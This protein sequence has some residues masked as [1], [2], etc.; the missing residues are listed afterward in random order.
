M[1]KAVFKKNRQDDDIRP[2]Y[3]FSTM[4]G[5]VRGTY[6]KAY[7]AGHKVEIHNADGTSSTQHIKLEDGAGMLE[8]DVKKYFPN[9]ESVNKTLRS[10]IAIFPAKRRTLAHT[11]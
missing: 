8:P 9:S 6:G 5:A 2:E 10:L 11:K 7:R 3:D 1:K 4:K